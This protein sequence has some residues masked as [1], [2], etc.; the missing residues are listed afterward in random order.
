MER[1]WEVPVDDYWKKL[2]A[3]GFVLFIA[4]LAVSIPSVIIIFYSA[5]LPTVAVLFI[6]YCF[7]DGYIGKAVGGHWEGVGDL[8]KADSDSERFREIGKI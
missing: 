1:I 8:G 2:L 7:I 4:L 6:I 3:H 5:N